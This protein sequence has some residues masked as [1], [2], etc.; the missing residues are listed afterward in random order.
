MESLMRAYACS[1][2]S[3]ATHLSLIGGKFNVTNPDRFRRIY[4]KM[5]TQG[6]YLVEKVRYPSRWYLDFD[7]VSPNFVH[8]T[9][10]PRL[11][12]SKE[13]CVVCVCRDTWDGVHVIFPN[14]IVNDKADA[15]SKSDAFV[16]DNPALSYDPSVYS[17]GLRMIGSKKNRNVT[18]VY[19]PYAFVDDTVRTIEGENLVTPDLLRA[20]SIQ[21]ED[22]SLPVIKTVHVS[23]QK[24]GFSTQGFENM[25]KF[26]A[27]Y[28]W[29]TKERYCDNIG[30]EHKS[31]NRMYELDFSR[32]RMRVRCSCKCK[33]TGCAEYRG[34][35]GDVPNKL[36]AYIQTHFHEEEHRVHRRFVNIDVRDPGAFVDN[37]FG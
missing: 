15:R 16:A 18:R 32:K 14:V 20:C 9:L 19:T 33:E 22:I 28:Y 35:W 21:C 4:A 34:Q 24:K 17:S 2:A 31:A 12:L 26:G 8:D 37:L 29:F 6:A 3:E 7:K 30:R 1:H 11:L 13:L 5:W 36:Y 25:K 10:I 23:E 27:H